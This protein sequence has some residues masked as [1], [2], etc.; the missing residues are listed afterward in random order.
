M[1]N[2]PALEVEMRDNEQAETSSTRTDW[3]QYRELQRQFERAMEQVREGAR[4]VNEGLDR[5][6]G[7]TKGQT[8]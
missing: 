3:S 6:Q 7:S 1:A 4:K 5:R 8:P 2:C